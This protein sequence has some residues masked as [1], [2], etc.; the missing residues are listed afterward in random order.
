ML[1]I[2]NRSVYVCIYT[3]VY[4]H[5]TP[6]I[7]LFADIHLISSAYLTTGISQQNHPRFPV[8]VGVSFS[9]V[10]GSNESSGKTGWCASSGTAQH[11]SCGLWGF[12]KIFR[13]NM[14]LWVNISKPKKHIHWVSNN[15][16]TPIAGWFTREHPIKLEI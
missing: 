14:W 5:D 16:G 15:E 2:E 11:A 7:H 12:P 6:Y 8:G 10:Y 1:F 3:C 4:I 9:E 13:H